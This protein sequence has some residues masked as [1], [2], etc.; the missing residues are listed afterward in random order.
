[1]YVHCSPVC[2]RLSLFPLNFHISSY[3]YQIAMIF[4]QMVEYFD[5]FVFMY[6]VEFLVARGETGWGSQTGWILSSLRF[7]K[8]LS[9]LFYYCAGWVRGLAAWVGCAL[10]RRKQRLLGASGCPWG[11]QPVWFGLAL[12]RPDPGEGTWIMLMLRIWFWVL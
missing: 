9:E 3:E 6:F 12:A 5:V 11:A 8:F 7:V 4:V 2:G 10:F 1:M